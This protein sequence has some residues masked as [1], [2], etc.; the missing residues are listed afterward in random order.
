MLHPERAALIRRTGRLPHDV[1]YFSPPEATLVPAL[2][3]GNTPALAAL[4]S[5]F[6]GPRAA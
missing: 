5:A 3:A 4:D 1:R 2:V 6:A